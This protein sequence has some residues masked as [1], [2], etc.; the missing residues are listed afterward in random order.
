VWRAADV[1]VSD[2]HDPKDDGLE[3]ALESRWSGHS[4][5][6]S[7]L[8]L[9]DRYRP[10]AADRAFDYAQ[11]LLIVL[12]AVLATMRGPRS[13]A[14]ADRMRDSPQEPGSHSG[15]T[16]PG[17]ADYGISKV[18]KSQFYDYR[19]R[20]SP[21]DRRHAADEAAVGVHGILAIVHIF[22]GLAETAGGCCCYART[23]T[24]ARCS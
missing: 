3:T 10:M 22:A 21:A 14:V 1:S 20:A 12:L 18:M 15:T 6:T 5:F 23:A 7:V 13:I 9:P 8:G 24:L 17:D 11:L 16:S 19:R 2:R 4:W